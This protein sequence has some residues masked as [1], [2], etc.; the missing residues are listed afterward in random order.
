MN[1]WLL[2]GDGGLH[3]LH[4]DPDFLIPTMDTDFQNQ[5]GRDGSCTWTDMSLVF[6][7]CPFVMWLVC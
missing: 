5:S 4:M 1:E 2:T 6:T 3:C 7:V